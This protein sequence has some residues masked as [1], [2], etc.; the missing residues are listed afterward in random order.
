MM[1]CRWLRRVR[2]HLWTRGVSWLW[3]APL[4]SGD[5]GQG[6][7]SVPCRGLLPICS[8]SLNTSLPRGAQTGNVESQPFPSALEGC[9]CDSSLVHGNA[10][11][12]CLSCRL[13]LTGCVCSLWNKTS[14]L[15]SVRKT[16]NYPHGIIHIVLRKHITWYCIKKVP[17]WQKYRRAWLDSWTKI[18]RFCTF[19]I[20][21]NQSQQF[22]IRILTKI[23]P[24]DF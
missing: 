12:T 11:V 13:S 5:P 1:V 16:K 6:G 14:P 17:T 3:R 23:A 18:Y 15:L 22:I 10:N 4:S 9:F 24:N 19:S 7:P 2:D 21:I 20:S 8:V